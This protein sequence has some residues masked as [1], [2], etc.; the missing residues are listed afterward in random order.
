[1]PRVFRVYQGAS[2]KDQILS[3]NPM[4]YWSFEETSGLAQ[5]QS[6][7][8]YHTTVN[9]PNVD[10]TVQGPTG[11]GVGID[12][13]S[14]EGIQFPTGFASMIDN[15][16]FSIH[17]FARAISFPET[18]ASAH[19]DA[20]TVISFL[21]EKQFFICQA[22]GASV[23]NALGMRGEY[24]NAGWQTF[25]DTGPLNTDQ[26]YQVVFTRDA[27]TGQQICYVDGVQV[28]TGTI[29]DTVD[30]RSN[31]NKIGG[32]SYGSTRTWD[33]DIAEVAIIPSVLTPTEVEN[34]ANTGVAWKLSALRHHDGTSFT[35][36]PIRVY[37]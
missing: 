13:A 8:G 21:G 35:S 10:M 31:E 6:G 7:N 4:A 11:N 32:S 18:S 19:A 26:W 30:G 1:M 36:R 12:Y 24:A 37:G 3:H 34:L 29:I 33:G 15:Q 25:V 2:L 14:G 16:D 28:D 23:Y 5:D 17:F 22:D 20:A 9:P 27:T